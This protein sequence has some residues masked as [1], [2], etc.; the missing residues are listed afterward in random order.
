MLGGALEFAVWS[1]N[2]GIRGTKENLCRFSM[3]VGASQCLR[4][5]LHLSGVEFEW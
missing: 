2:R 1:V 3:C 4:C 5:V